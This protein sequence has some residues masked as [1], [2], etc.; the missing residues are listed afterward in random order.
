MDNVAPGDTDRGAAE[1][2]RH[3]RTA[4]ACLLQPTPAI[5]GT[6]TGIARDL[7]IAAEPFVR[8]LF[9]GVVGWCDGNCNGQWVR[10]IRSGI[11]RGDRLRLL[12]GAGIVAGSD[13]ESEWH[14]VQA[15][16]RTM[17]HACGVSA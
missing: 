11:V 7:I 12:A 9:S 17:R 10:A 2:S 3:D 8:G 14:E 4:L 15:K 16:L 5:C 1:E 6:P 13:P